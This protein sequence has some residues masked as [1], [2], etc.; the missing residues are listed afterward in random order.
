[1]D[2]ALFLRRE[3][4]LFSRAEAPEAAVAIIIPFPSL[5][6]FVLLVLLPFMMSRDGSPEVGMVQLP[7]RPSPFFN[8]SV[9]KRKESLKSESTR[10]LFFYYFIMRDD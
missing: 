1:M 5:I 4:E 6:M 9:N 10:I 7:R 3:G 8:L 2:E